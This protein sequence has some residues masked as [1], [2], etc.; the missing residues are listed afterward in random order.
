MQSQL[1]HQTIANRMQLDATH[2]YWLEM[3]GHILCGV[4]CF[5]LQHP[6]CSICI[7][8][9][10]E[11]WMFVLKSSCYRVPSNP[12]VAQTWL[13]VV[14]SSCLPN[15][16]LYLYPQGLFVLSVFLWIQETSSQELMQH[17]PWET[18]LQHWFMV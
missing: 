18:W 3:W 2:A 4:H 5:W 17:P 8:F 6:L 9:H 13:Q 1:P 7:S 12:F 16:R 15:L 10:T 14:V 11:S